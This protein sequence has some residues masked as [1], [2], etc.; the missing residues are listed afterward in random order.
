MRIILITGMIIFLTASLCRAEI[1]R[2]TDSSGT[3]HHRNIPDRKAAPGKKK[4]T[5]RR[6]DRIILSKSAKY[7]LSPSLIKAMIKAESSWDPEAVSKKGAVGL[8]Q[9][10]PSTAREMKVDP[11][12]PE[13]NIEGGSRY[14]RY[15]L[16]RF[17]GR[18][19]IAL[20]AYNAGPT[21]V[22]K[23]GGIPSITE[24]RNYVRKVLSDSK[25][26]IRPG[27]SRIHKIRLRN[28]SV[29]FTNTPSFYNSRAL[30]NF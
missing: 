27:A 12:S 2:Y 17:N 13:E 18:L 22:E 11:F 14:M 4:R 15:L 16:D 25:I 19:D 30:P 24:T 10:M 20:A 9:L 5:L 6:Y 21:A 1:I 8:M 26:G 29:L 28:G 3:I 7:R 23:A